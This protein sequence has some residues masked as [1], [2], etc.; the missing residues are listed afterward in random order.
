MSDPVAFN[1][2]GARR[3]VRTVRQVEATPT[4]QHPKRG[5]S[6]VLEHRPMF[7]RIIA[8]P[9]EGEPPDRFGAIQ[10]VPQYDTGTGSLTF[11]VP[12][13]ALEFDDD[14]YPKLTAVNWSENSPEVRIGDVVRIYFAQ[15]NASL[16]GN[17][18]FVWT[19]PTDALVG[20]A[21]DS[22]KT[23]A[24]QAGTI[25]H[26]NGAVTT[27]SELSGNIK[28][29]G[30]YDTD[31]P[32]NGYLSTVPV[33]IELVETAGDDEDDIVYQAVK[34]KSED[35]SV[36]LDA[37]TTPGV[38]D[39]SVDFPDPPEDTTGIITVKDDDG[40]AFTRNDDGVVQFIGDDTSG[41]IPVRSD[42]DNNGGGANDILLRQWINEEDLPGGG[43]T[44]GEY[45][46]YWINV[47]A[48]PGTTK[49]YIDSQSG[50]NI[51]WRGRKVEI[52]LRW[53]QDTEAGSLDRFWSGSSA[54]S[55]RHWGTDYETTGDESIVSAADVIG[56][57][58]NM[59]L[60]IET[61]SGGPTGRMYFQRTGGSWTHH[62]QVR[63]IVRASAVKTEADVDVS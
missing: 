13:Q 12:P 40:D 55:L 51:D 31:S 7:A 8:L 59:T 54:P 36:I 57:G 4:N 3:V 48:D 9:K 5:K 43:V 27:V 30:K 2:E 1:R 18:Y 21:Y 19:N 24:F 26:Q 62:G 44:G 45:V 53:V 23:A 22:M 28:F 6:A 47:G 16:P 49:Y 15:P 34:I 14:E 38:L 41:R 42:G 50:G 60:Y 37:V 33:H 25:T 63:V 35:N 32:G 11:P 56:A 58:L 29:S 52:L 17:W 39:L 20:D 61:D 46:D 10:V